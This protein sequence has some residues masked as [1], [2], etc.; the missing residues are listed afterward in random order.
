[1]IGRTVSHYR[2]L[3]RQGGGGMGVVFKAEDLNLA[4]IVALK[5]L[6]EKLGH[7]DEAVERFTRE[8]KAA[9]A[10][11]HPNICTIHEIG[12]WE[13]EGFIV[14]ELLEGEPLNHRIAASPLAVSEILELGVQI[15]DG[16]KA[17]HAKG[18]VHR[19]IKPAN[20][21]ITSGG[22]V[23]ILDFGLA[24]MMPEPAN[25]PAATRTEHQ[26]LTKTGV[27][28][29]TAAY[30]SPEQARGEPV[31]RRT[32]LFSFGVV[33]YE[34]T[35][36]RLPFQ[37]KS[38]AA[39]LGEVLHV[40]PA[41]PSARRPDIPAELDR[42]VLKALEKDR[43]LRYQSATE[44]QSDLVLLQ[45][46]L[47][48]A[49]KP[50]QAPRRAHWLRTAAAAIA[51]VL[52]VIAG[53]WWRARPRTRLS[54]P[55]V[56]TLQTEVHPRRSVAVLGFQNLTG[57]PEAAW[58]STA[59]SEMLSTE[60]AAGEELRVIPGENVAR[61]RIDLSLT[62]SGAF[63]EQ[64]LRRI[65]QHLGTD[66]VV[67]G[68]YIDLGPAAGGQIRLDLRLQD[69]EAGTTVASISETGTEANL[70]EL[71]SQTGSRL[72]GKLGIAG[73]PDKE[74]Q[75]VQA[76]LP[77]SPELAR[78]YSEGLNSLRVFDIEK[79]KSLF[80]K[81]VVGEPD[82]ARGRAALSLAYSALG[83]DEKAKQEAKRAFNLSSSLS[84]EDR[85]YIEGR[86]REASRDWAAAA[87]VHQ[88]LFQLFPDNIDYGLRLA[89]D[90]DNDGK[91]ND[92]LATVQALRRLKAPLRDDPRIDLAQ[93]DAIGSRGEFPQQV[94]LARSAAAKAKE[95]GSGMVLARAR[96]ME[97]RALWRSGKPADAGQP[98]REAQELYTKAGNYQASAG[99]MRTIGGLA[100]DAGDYEKARSELE[101]ALAVFRRIGARGGIANTLNDLGNAYY[102]QGNYQAAKK[103]Y[104]QSLDVLRELDDKSG[105][106]GGLGNLANVLD[107]Q[108][109]LQAAEKMQRE[110]I[111]AFGAVDDQRGVAAT[112]NNLGMLLAEQGRLLP[113]K[114][115]NED[116][117][118]LHQKIGFR[119]GSAY[120]LQSIG[121]VLEALGDLSG[122][123]NAFQKALTIRREL[124][125]HGNVATTQVDL[126]ELSLEEGNAAVAEDQARQSVQVFAS[127]KDRDQ[128]AWGGAV[129]AR[130]L[131]A[132]K[133]LP[134][135]QTAISRAKMTLPSG[136]SY[137][138][139]FAVSLAG[140]R[141]EMASDRSAE[142]AIQA[143]QVLA[144]AAQY[145]YAGYALEARL[146]LGEL[147][148]KVDR[149]A[150]AR[151][152]QDLE[153]EAQ[154]RSY[155]LIARKAHALRTG[156]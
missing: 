57:K 154:S 116:A 141:V 18:I 113:A 44:L 88:T 29:G 124:G 16:L 71:V 76:S 125:E 66:L 32:D 48:A 15:A 128:E 2:I 105:I 93:G 90:Q 97:G 120:T 30:M 25:S 87:Q 143:R 39:M 1:M 136:A 28:M 115:T 47:G 40:T 52:I 43:D 63:S 151:Q 72:R 121:E 23:K 149:A 56:S 110:T 85:L 109:E 9:S 35:T 19:D 106:A 101:Q 21:F 126:A 37:G 137:P 145:G 94:Q 130:A 134:S 153:V 129:L 4:R 81:V 82:Y 12:S 22:H 144:Q 135:A 148:M 83:Y 61:T 140:A 51:V 3:E 42:I 102:T 111:E 59:L 14:M 6:S 17:A 24:K 131:L 45:R 62:E 150:G 54:S 41:A 80:E 89:Y 33:L 46:Q 36:G 75:H 98:L 13:G 31:D 103:I 139:R 79:A 68:S 127:Q 10:L 77:S 60:L 119:S 92:S 156:S 67:L 78:L 49:Q 34:M 58:L 146:V 84:R 20:T 55:H 117:L 7:D 53:L 155:M 123:R 95:Q 50:V 86:Y 69:T 122:A 38:Q 152:L 96:A 73:V 108:G 74:Q 65:R 26:S 5:F 147:K 142:A 8:A 118:A 133:K 99:I 132:Q 107:S 138:T 27:A 100:Y 104:Q 112:M 11:N 64:T 114:Q 70:F 91:P